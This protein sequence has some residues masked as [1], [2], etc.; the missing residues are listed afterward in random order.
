MNY[1]L[2]ISEKKDQVK[3]D[4]E[5]KQEIISNQNKIRA[6]WLTLENKNIK[7]NDYNS[8]I[9]IS[10]SNLFNSGFHEFIKYYGFKND[11][12]KKNAF[13]TS[14]NRSGPY[15]NGLKVHHIT[16]KHL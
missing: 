7:F 6:I 9:A 11:S 2:F 13:I 16:Q 4:I 1:I 3:K 5:V 10:D 12:K 8:N 14:K 15:Q